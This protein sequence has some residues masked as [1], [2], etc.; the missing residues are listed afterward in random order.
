MTKVTE[1]LDR[2]GESI[3]DLKQQVR[4]LQIALGIVREHI[5]I[6]GPAAER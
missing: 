2:H 3:S 4:A 1:R 5:L 6:L